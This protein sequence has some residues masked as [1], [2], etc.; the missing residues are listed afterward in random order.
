M[1]SV[2]ASD[3]P[4]HEDQVTGKLMQELYDKMQ[5]NQAGG[6]H[7]NELSVD[8]KGKK[9]QQMLK[10]KVYV[11]TKVGASISPQSPVL[12]GDSGG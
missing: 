11:N 9:Q 7:L 5:W 8:S 1:G 6:R 10:N 12:G 2:A 4:S 3:C